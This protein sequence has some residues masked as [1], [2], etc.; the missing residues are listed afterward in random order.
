MGYGF[1]FKSRLRAIQIIPKRE[2]LPETLRN[3]Q[4]GPV[5]NLQEEIPTSSIEK[6]MFKFIEGLKAEAASDK[7]VIIL[8]NVIV[9]RNP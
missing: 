7:N 9:V 3:I 6:S 2:R 8:L 4:R 5:L 1:Q